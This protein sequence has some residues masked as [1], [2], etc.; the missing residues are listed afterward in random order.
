MLKYNHGEKSIKDPFI[1]YSDIQS[2]LEKTDACHNP[3]NTSTTKINKHTA[4]DYSLFAHCHLVLQKTSMI[5][6]EA[7]IV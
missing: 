6:I 2:L 1:I 4:S 7:K 5:I 3:E